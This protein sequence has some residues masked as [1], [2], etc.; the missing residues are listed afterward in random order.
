MLNKIYATGYVTLSVI[1]SIA[2]IMLGISALA[3]SN[4]NE[5]GSCSSGNRF[6]GTG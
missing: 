1:I 5:Y 3:I 6:D 2:A 4:T